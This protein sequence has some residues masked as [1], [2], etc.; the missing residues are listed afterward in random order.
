MAARVPV[1]V[2]GAD[3]GADEVVGAT[4]AKVCELLRLLRVDELEDVGRVG[5]TADP[6]LLAADGAADVREDVERNGSAV[7]TRLMDGSAECGRAFFGG[8]ALDELAD[9][10]DDG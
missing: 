2:H 1:D 4:G 8:V 5:E 10:V 9:L 7:F 3:L 6:A